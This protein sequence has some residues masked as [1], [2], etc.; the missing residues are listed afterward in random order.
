M[1]V[2]C[3]DCGKEWD[4]DPALEVSCPSCS[5][6]I[7]QRCKRPSGHKCRIHTERDRRALEEVYDYSKCPSTSAPGRLTAGSDSSPKQDEQTS[8][9]TRQTTL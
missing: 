5:A 3:R 7:G 9:T 8:D 6:E 2:T 1:G 4:Q